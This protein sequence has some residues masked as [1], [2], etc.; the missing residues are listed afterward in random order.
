MVEVTKPPITTTAN[1]F[2]VSEPMPVDKAAGNKPM[3]AISA[4]ITT[5]RTRDITPCNTAS[6]K[7]M[8]A[9]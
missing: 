8:P 2:C 9:S 5:G 7:C 6:S 4:V 3:A 1:G